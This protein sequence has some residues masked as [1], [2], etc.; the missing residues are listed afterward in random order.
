MINIIR[1]TVR[2]YLCNTK[3]EV[4]TTE[5]NHREARPD[6]LDHVRQGS[7]YNKHFSINTYIKSNFYNQL[8]KDISFVYVNDLQNTNVY[9]YSSNS[10]QDKLL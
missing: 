4:S 6:N 9:S 8:S 10:H 2:L 3:K 7:P 5:Q 1:E